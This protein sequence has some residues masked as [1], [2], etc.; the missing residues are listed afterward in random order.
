MQRKTSLIHHLI[1]LSSIVVFCLA[2][3]AWTL[4]ASAQS[5]G[6]IRVVHASPDVGVVD[7]FVDGK[8]LLSNFQFATVTQYE[9][10]PAG[11]HNVQIALLGK[12]A[13]ASMLSQKLIVKANATYTVAVLGTRETG[14]S[15][16]VFADNNLISGNMA[17]LRVYHL[18]PGTNTVDIKQGA[19]AIIQSLSYPRASNYVSLPAGQHTFS[20][21][22][23][24]QA[25]A[26]TFNATLKPWTV[27]SIFAIGQ[28][29]GS[30]KLQFVTTQVQGIPSMPNTGSD[31]TLLVSE[32]SGVPV[33]PIANPWLAVLL[34]AM[35]AGI[36]SGWFYLT[37]GRHKREEK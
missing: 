1:M 24:S 34:L 29:N 7:V 18:S 15:F 27:T 5:L 25:T 36:G 4:P 6:F 35:V 20:L 8:M 17:K 2:L 13:N 33:S 11:S 22:A 16:E 9:P 28:F 31:P 21:D 32:A 26:A 19:Q 14:L 10:L 3:S 37:A 30:R 23:A 12:G